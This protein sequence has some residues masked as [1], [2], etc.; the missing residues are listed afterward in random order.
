VISY[1]EDL[2]HRISIPWAIRAVGTGAADR[3]A[4]IDALVR[5]RTEA[6]LY[7]RSEGAVTLRDQTLFDT[8]IRLPANL[9]EG[10]YRTRIFLTRGGD[11]V[12]VFSQ[13][14][15]VRKVGLERWIFNLAYDRPLAYGLL[16]LA[17]AI[18]AGWLASAVFRYLRS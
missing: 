12:D 7:Q 4:F 11:V 16:S 5:V 1:T 9:V 8:S 14:I 17:I 6:G 10:A 2:R 3:D 13:D 15:S 18:A